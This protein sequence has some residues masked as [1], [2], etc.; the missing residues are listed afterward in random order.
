[1]K[2]R[3]ERKHLV[4]PEGR[5]RGDPQDA[6]E[7]RIGA[8][9]ERGCLG[10]DVERWRAVVEEPP[11][12]GRQAHRPRGA[13]GE[14]DAEPILRVRTFWLTAAGET[15]RARA[16]AEKLPS[17]AACAKVTR[18]RRSIMRISQR[19][20]QVTSTGE[21]YL[22]MAPER[23]FQPSPR[24][25]AMTVLRHIPHRYAPTLIA[26]AFPLVLLLSPRV[27]AL[28]AALTG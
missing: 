24:E 14:P 4:A 28:L 6:G 5:G 8:G 18:R 27:R 3:H 15:C 16:A 20:L 25:L 7:R 1:L 26:Q 12:L 2:G 11:P 23:I 13:L 9:E 17:R 10:Q 22:R 21:G 19:R